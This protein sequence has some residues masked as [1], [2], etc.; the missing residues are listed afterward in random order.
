MNIGYMEPFDY[1]TLAMFFLIIVG[2]GIWSKRTVKSS[3][4]FYVGGGKVPWWLSG[5]SHHVSGYS[6][7]VRGNCI[8]SG[9]R[10]LFLVGD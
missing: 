4:D 2:I 9:N 5:I 8:C 6:G 7:V 10:N 1:V 3:E